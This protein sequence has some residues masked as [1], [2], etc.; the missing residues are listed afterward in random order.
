MDEPTLSCSFCGRDA[1][2]VDKLIAGPD[3]YIC[4]HCVKLSADIL[5]YTAPAKD[6]ADKTAVFTVDYPG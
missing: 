3:V 4:N 2:A 6:A 5:G 1:A